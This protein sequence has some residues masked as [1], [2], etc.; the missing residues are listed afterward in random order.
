MKW[1]YLPVPRSQNTSGFSS[2][3]DGG[4]LNLPW[5]PTKMP[6]LTYGGNDGG[7]KT[8]PDGLPPEV[9]RRDAVELIGAERLVRVLKAVDPVVL[10]VE[11]ARGRVE[12]HT[13]RVPEARRDAGE[14][15]DRGAETY[16]GHR[17]AVDRAA[18]HGAGEQAAQP[19]RVRVL[20]VVRRGTDIEVELP[21]AGRRARRRARRHR[22]RLVLPD[23][24]ERE[25]QRANE[26]VGRCRAVVHLEHDDPVFAVL[27]AH[28]EDHVSRDRETRPDADRVR[29]H[30]LPGAVGDAVVVGIGEAKELAGREP[31][32]T[33]PVGIARRDQDG[34]VRQPRQPVREVQSRGERGDP[35]VVRVDPWVAADCELRGG[36]IDRA[37]DESGDADGE[38]DEGSDQT[39]GLRTPSDGDWPLPVLEANR[40][41]NRECAK[42]D[43]FRAISAPG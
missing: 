31:E 22:V 6:L 17:D 4:A 39:H 32:R 28:D 14:A 34:A 36:R 18:L 23:P 2:L 21:R 5:K 10:E 43:T 35:E 1:K 26:R 13:R 25:V 41:P 38:R 42:S 12:R 37:G 15:G 11:V 19:D 40:L 9:G 7:A 16:F 3:P 24:G 8:I 27:R 29:V 20:V 30:Q 33:L